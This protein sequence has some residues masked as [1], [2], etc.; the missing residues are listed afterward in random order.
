VTELA[1]DAGNRSARKL[2]K[3]AL[4]TRT[5]RPVDG[6]C[7]LLIG[8]LTPPFRWEFVRFVMGITAG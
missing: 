6:A 3:G 4:Q 8:K 5:D 1:A 2:P 7:I